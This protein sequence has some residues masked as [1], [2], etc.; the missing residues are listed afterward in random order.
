MSR[1]DSFLRRLTAQRDCLNR[2][3]E[4][5]AG[6]AGPVLEVG[7]GNGRTYDHLRTILPG[8]EIF[9]FDRHID[10][11]P[12]CIPDA[13][14]MILGDFLETLPA[15]NARIGRPAGRARPLRHRQRRLGCQPPTGRSPGALDRRADGARRHRRL[16]SADGRAALAT[17]AA[18]R[19]CATW[20]LSHVAG[21]RLSLEWRAPS[22][23]MRRRRSAKPG[24]A[25][26]RCRS[27]PAIRMVWSRRMTK[28]CS[29]ADVEAKLLFFKP[30]FL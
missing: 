20:P 29:S 3:A 2:A 14:H 19:R 22:S 25:S 13:G 15:A 9:V 28:N 17:A 23:Y 10:A 27:I 12:D 18:A 16:R 11:H 4:L 24:P 5:V 7:L 26:R 1:L 8:R 21:R 30:L 6:L